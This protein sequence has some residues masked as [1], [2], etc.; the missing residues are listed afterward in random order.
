MP[1]ST[2]YFNSMMKI[3]YWLCWLI[4]SSSYH[5]WMT[6]T[7]AQ[8]TPL[9][10]T[11]CSTITSRNET[12]QHDPE[13][14]AV[15]TQDEDRFLNLHSSSLTTS[16][17]SG[18]CLDYLSDPDRSNAMLCQ[19]PKIKWLFIKYNTDLP[20]SAAVERLFCSASIVLCKRRNRLSDDTFWKATAAET[21]QALSRLI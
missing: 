14:D 8:Y 17:D 19:Y 3:S 12:E 2:T 4:L 13:S 9:L 6:Q 20:S 11:A 7:R 5:G 1:Y 10:E 15:E 16:T 21:E 18:Q